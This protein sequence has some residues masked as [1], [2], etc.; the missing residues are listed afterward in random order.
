MLAKCAS[1][2]AASSGGASRLRRF[3]SLTL[4]PVTSLAE[5][6]SA[7]RAFGQRL[8]ALKAA[9]SDVVWYPYGTLGL[10]DVLRRLLTPPED[11]LFARLAG[12][13]VL[14]LGCAD[15]D[16]SFFLESQGYRVQACDRPATN[17]NLS[18]GFRALHAE[19]HSQVPF[20]AVDL[21]HPALPPGP[22][23][24]TVLL[25]V[26]YHL[27]NPV[28]ILEELALRSRYLLVSTRVMRR[29]PDGRD[30]TGLPVAWFL[31]HAQTNQDAT[32]YWILTQ[33]A[34]ELMLKRA[35][36]EIVRR[37]NH[38]VTSGS[39]PIREDR[40][41]RLFCLARSRH[42]LVPG[43]ELTDG[44]YGVEPGPFR[45]TEPE[46]GFVLDA[47][48]GSTLE[49]DFYLATADRVTLTAFVNGVELETCVFAAAGPATYRAAC[50]ASGVLDIRFRVEGASERDGRPYG[51]VVPLGHSP[52]RVS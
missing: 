37:L 1:A 22:T 26:L 12:G 28:T 13:R 39:E 30:L 11:T 8:A 6:L 10:L 2:G 40:D 41:E 17:H 48:A 52:I 18:S 51:V 5:F 32:N 38:G 36:W 46:F 20:T 9:R 19:L 7:G 34:F 35:G 24:L 16:L 3:I 23:D 29:A 25:G 14:D 50:P 31:D 42:Y 47:A 43:G 21:D 45:W 44:W 49:L 33:A 4:Y 15:G 27:K